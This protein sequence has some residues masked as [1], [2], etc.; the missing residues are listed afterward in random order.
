MVAL[1]II[2]KIL[3]HFYMANYRYVA[4]LRIMI[5]AAAALHPMNTSLT[6]CEN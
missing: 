2:N 1:R 4:K 5:P 3:G 6:G